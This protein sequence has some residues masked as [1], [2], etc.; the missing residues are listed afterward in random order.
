M[1][2]TCATLASLLFAAA[3]A[4]QGGTPSGWR[5]TWSDEFSGSSLDNSRWFAQN[6]AWPYNNEQQYYTPS[7][8]TVSG[9]LLRITADRRFFGGRPYTSGRIE[10]AGRFSQQYG[11][12]EARIKL[13]RTQGLWPAFWLLPSPSGWPPEIDIMEM[14]GHEPTRVYFTNH[15]GT[16][17]NLRSQTSSFA[18]PDFSEDFHVF[19]AEWYPDRIDFFVDGVRHATHRN[20][21]P[22][23]NM[24]IILNTAVGGFWPGYPDQTTIFPQHMLVDYVRVY[25]PTLANASFEEYG[26]NGTTPLF[27]WT[28]WGNRFIEIQRPRTHTRSAKLFGNFT[29]APNTSGLWQQAPASPGQRWKAGAWWLNPANDFMRSTNT[30]DTRIEWINAAGSVISTLR[31]PSLNANSPRDI[32]IRSAVEGIAPPGTAFA[33]LVLTFNQPG[34]SAAGAAFI[35]DAWLYSLPACPAD[36]NNDGFVDFFD[37]DDFITCFEGRECPPERS[38]DFNDDGF[39]DFFDFDEFMS[40]F[41]QSCD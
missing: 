41:D 5:L 3:A 22:Q 20:S 16:V 19:A 9:G 33:R 12:F 38:S 28:G 40:A 23:M 37:F 2:P 30:T 17:D 18:G 8:V 6:I 15:W 7:A 1:R 32:Y 35:D 26:P 21:I 39:S 10:S 11:R 25:Q 13:P 31:V 27:R 36:F 29:G 4:A 24:F 14:L 34:G